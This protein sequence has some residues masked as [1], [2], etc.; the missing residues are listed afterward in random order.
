VLAD[1]AVL[2]LANAVVLM[3]AIAAIL[4]L[5][6]AA[7]L[8]LAADLFLAFTRLRV[9]RQLALFV[10]LFAV[11]ALFGDWNGDLYNSSIIQKYVCGIKTN[12][13][14]GKYMYINQVY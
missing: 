11:L 7:V 2:T 9:R 8:A 1:A 5:A 6:N 12:L 14:E 3:L 10:V 4:V 13:K